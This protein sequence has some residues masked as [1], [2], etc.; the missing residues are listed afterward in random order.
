MRTC[1]RPWHRPWHSVGWTS[2]RL[3]NDPYRDNSRSGQPMARGAAGE[4][5]APAA[6]AR[7]P[8]AP[9]H[10]QPVGAENRDAAPDQVVQGQRDRPRR[11]RPQ[12]AQHDLPPWRSDSRT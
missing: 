9:A 7:R 4:D 10:H 3:G 6:P 12:P 11:H 8:P 5:P 2:R 1:G